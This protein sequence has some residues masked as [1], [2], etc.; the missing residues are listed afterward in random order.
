MRNPAKVGDRFKSLVVS[1]D[2]G[3]STDGHRL[4]VCLCDCGRE[5]VMQSNKLKTFKV[6][7]CEC[8]PPP[9]G[10]TH[11]MRQSSAYSSWAASITRCHNI[12]SESY[13]RYG[14]KGISVC[15]E[16]RESFKAFYDYMGPR[17]PGTTLDRWP[18]R[19]GNYEPGNCRW[20]TPKEQAINRDSTLIVEWDGK[21]LGLSDVADILH[22]PY[23][24][25]HRKFHKGLL[26]PGIEAAEPHQSLS[27]QILTD[28]HIR[29]IRRLRG[30]ESQRSLARRFGVS[31][32]YIARVQTWE[33]RRNVSQEPAP[34]IAELTNLGTSSEPCPKAM[35]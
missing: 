25:A 31:S 1:K 12:N 33:K 14:A 8:L 34:A 2:G 15:E 5:Y 28:D 19:R 3:R 18:N 4:W 9:C 22:I 21:G 29:E 16:W 10:T 30:T 32:G 17:P 26:K 11:G 27:T 35:D 7:N 24:T 20:A 6:L 23:S 13:A